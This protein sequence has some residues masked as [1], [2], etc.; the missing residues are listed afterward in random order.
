[1]QL[2]R[3]EPRREWRDI[4]TGVDGAGLDEEHRKAVFLRKVVGSLQPGLKLVMRSRNIVVSGDEAR[5]WI[6]LRPEG[7]F[8]HVDEADQEDPLNATQ[9]VRALPDLRRVLER[10]EAE[11]RGGTGPEA[12]A[13]LARVRAARQALE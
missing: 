6:A 11:L 2:T 9:V 1:M 10:I 8:V 3:A 13:A 7:T 12:D 5:P 4:L